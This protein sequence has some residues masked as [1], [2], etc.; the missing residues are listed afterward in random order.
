MNVPTE[1]VGLVKM[2]RRGSTVGSS[3]GKTQGNQPSS[4]LCHLADPARRAGVADRDTSMDLGS[5][6]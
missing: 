6:I 2:L 1:G 5:I 4:F 3:P